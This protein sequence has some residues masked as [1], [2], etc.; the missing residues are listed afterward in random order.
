MSDIY[1]YIPTG[2]PQGLTLDPLFGFPLTRFVLLCDVWHHIHYG[3]D[4]MQPVH[5]CVSLFAN[6][7]MT[8]FFSCFLLFQQSWQQQWREPAGHQQQNLRLPDCPWVSYLFVNSTVISWI[9]Q[10]KKL[11]LFLTVATFV[12]SQQ[13]SS[14]NIQN[15]WLQI[16]HVDAVEH[17]FGHA[18]LR[19]HS[20]W[21]RGVWACPDLSVS[22]PHTQ[23]REGRKGEV[24]CNQIS[25]PPFRFQIPFWTVASYK[26]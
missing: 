11:N 1:I 17:E 14:F 15:I 23:A 9:A 6:G 25:L 12:G 5:V 7:F 26:N 3:E 21:T 4:S 2:L 16:S 19:P 18:L 20:L 10:K 24:S 13:L 22:L 8:C